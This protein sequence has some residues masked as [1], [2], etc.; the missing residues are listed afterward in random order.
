LR[1]HIRRLI[2]GQ[3]QHGTRNLI[4]L[5]SSPQRV[6][7]P[8][9]LLTAPRPRRV[10]RGLGHAGLDEARTHGI[11]ADARADELVRTRLHERDDGGFGGRVVCGSCVGSEACDAGGADDGAAGVRLLGAGLEHG[12]R[13]V[14]CCQEHAE[15]VGAHHVH[16]ACCIFLPEYSPAADAGIGEE[17]VQTAVLVEGVLHY[18]LH[19]GFVCGVELAGVDVDGGIQCIQLALV[20]VEI[21]G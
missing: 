8:N 11:A 5:A 1:I 10:I 7:L 14:L 17:D 21:R 6:Q 9:L 18:L 16:E 20:G 15:G 12:A 4:R 19:G 2:A 13:R 3:E